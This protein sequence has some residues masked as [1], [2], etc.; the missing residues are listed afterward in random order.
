M[1][2]GNINGIWFIKCA[3]SSCL[4]LTCSPG[5]PHLYGHF[6]WFIVLG[7]GE[8]FRVSIAIKMNAN[9][10]EKKLF[11]SIYIFKVLSIISDD[12]ALVPVVILVSICC[13][14]G[15]SIYISAFHRY[16][17]VAPF[18]WFYRQYNNLYI[19]I[20]V[21][22]CA[23]IAVQS[24]IILP[25]ILIKTPPEVLRE[26]F[27]KTAPQ[28]EYFF[29]NEPSLFGY[30]RSVK[31][32]ATAFNRVLIIVFGILFLSIIFLMGNYLRIMRK[33]KNSLEHGALRCQVSA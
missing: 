33:N 24:V 18:S 23:F 16:V 13:G 28:L 25:V 8:V 10:Y 11:R 1:K 19:R 30:Y 7:S 6:T 5:N 27:L 26:Q 21:Y 4:T 29:T 12:F 9:V 32:Q 3:G 17:Q 15:F 20:P 2:W 31:M 22:I 14:M